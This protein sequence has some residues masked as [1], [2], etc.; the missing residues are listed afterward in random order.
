MM[1]EQEV[2]AALVEAREKFL[3]LSEAS[4]ARANYAINFTSCAPCCAYSRHDA[5]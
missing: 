2:R 5:M 4:Y 3:V 1:D